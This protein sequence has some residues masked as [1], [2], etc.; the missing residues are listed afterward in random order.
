MLKNTAASLLR[1]IS[2]LKR[3]INITFK[4]CLKPFEISKHLTH[5]KNANDD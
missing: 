1:K 3:N 2:S 4:T 5:R